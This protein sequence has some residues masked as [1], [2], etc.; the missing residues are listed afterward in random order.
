MLTEE[1]K[2]RRGMYSSEENTFHAPQIGVH[3]QY[4]KRSPISNKESTTISK[5]I[6]LQHC[7]AGCKTVLCNINTSQ[8]TCAAKHIRK[9]AKLCTLQ[10]I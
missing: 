9:H 10:V 6:L 7:T 1:I 3:R 8:G 4:G 2:Q 5:R